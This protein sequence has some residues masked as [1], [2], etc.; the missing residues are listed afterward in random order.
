VYVQDFCLRPSCY[1]LVLT[2]A[3]NN[4]LCC[5]NGNGEAIVYNDHGAPLDTIAEF[6]YTDVFRFCYPE[7]PDSMGI[8]QVYP[9]PNNGVFTVMV[10]PH[11]LGENLELRLADMSGRIV[12]TQAF[13]AG[14]VTTIDARP[15]ATGVYAAYVYSTVL[16]QTGM[17]RILVVN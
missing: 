5:A 16:R 2:D 4:G 1:R 14:Y 13:T 15:L 9:V 7:Y 8:I 3:G 12:F 11:M 6:I 17:R 10:D